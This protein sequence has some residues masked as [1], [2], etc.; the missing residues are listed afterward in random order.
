MGSRKGTKMDEKKDSQACEATP[1]KAISFHY[2]KGNHFRVIH[3]DGANG[4]V[5]PS[6]FI[7]M[8]LFSERVAIPRLMVYR[9]REDGKLGEEIQDQRE[10]REGIVREVEVLAVIDPPTA[11]SIALW[12]NNHADIAESLN[13]RAAKGGGA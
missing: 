6:G 2:L 10:S 8:G 5:A 7:Q 11:R 13:L 3:V 9:I 1:D 4:G 12:L